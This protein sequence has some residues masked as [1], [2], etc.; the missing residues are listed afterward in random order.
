MKVAIIH[1]W[2]TNMGGAE[3]LLLELHKLYPDAPIYTSVFDKSSMP[4][5]ENINVKTTFLQNLPF[6]KYK[7]QLWSPLRPLAF[8]KLKL[9]EYDIVISVDTAEAK[10]IKVRNDALHICYCNSPI[11]YFWSHYNEY[12]KDPG[13]GALNPLVKLFLPLFVYPLRKTDYKAAQK[14]DYFISNSS[15]VK[16]RVRKY[17]N[18]TSVVINP[19]VR[20]ELF[21]PPKSKKQRV[22][23]VIASRQTPYK[24]VD[25]AIRACNELGI[26]LTVIGSG[27]EHEKLKSIAGPTINMLGHIPDNKVVEEFQKAEGF[28]FPAEEDFGIVPVEAMS[29]GCPLIAYSKGGSTDWMVNNKT[30]I[31][32]HPQT[33]EAL[34]KAL[35]EFSP[36]NYLDSK[37]LHKHAEKFSPEQ[38]RLRIKEFVDQKYSELTK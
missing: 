15:E 36:K 32:F 4:A 3:N 17:Y 16:Q 9:E 25:L 30:G 22:G 29:T 26:K 28:I 24:K 33:K 19:P 5:F 21:K 23:F 34:K 11:R 18:R 20:T 35:K 2:L 1:P 38:F 12:K 13:F 7:Q 6:L 8:R 14:V 37:E 31:S 10:N 27:T